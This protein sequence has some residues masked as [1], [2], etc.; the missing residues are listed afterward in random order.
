MGNLSMSN[1]GLVS[2]SL[3][4]LF[5]SACTSSLQGPFFPSEASS[6]G[7]SA[8]QYSFVFSIFELVSFLASFPMVKLMNIFGYKIVTV[9]ST[10]LLGFSVTLFGWFY[11]VKNSTVFFFS[12]LFGRTLEAVGS[13]GLTTGIMTISASHFPDT[14]IFVIALTETSYGLGFVFGPSISGPIYDKWGYIGPFLTVGLVIYIFAILLVCV[15]PKDEQNI[16]E[17]D[18]E[19]RSSAGITDI[20]KVKRLWYGI[21]VLGSCAISGTMLMTF[22]GPHLQ[23]Y[24]F[25][26]SEI[27]ELLSVLGVS[28]G[29]GTLISGW[30]CYKYC[31]PHHAMALGSLLSIL[32]FCSIGPLPF[33]KT[34]LTLWEVI[35]GIFLIGLGMAAQSLPSFFFIK[36]VRKNN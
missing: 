30:L 16:I 25:S 6:K 2:A 10:V 24:N 3:A 32:G 19:T 1:L 11:Y 7:L 21:P 17:S 23:N 33:L 20:L 29:V 27:S 4:A 9:W 15:L 36:Q 34:E 13:S 22:M 26:A 12:C 14:G 18:S 28:Y 5:L 8:L 35:I 31:K